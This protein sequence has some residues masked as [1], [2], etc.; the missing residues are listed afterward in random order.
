MLLVV[1]VGVTSVGCSSMWDAIR[2]KQRQSSITIAREFVKRGEWVRAMQSLERAQTRRQLGDFAAESVYLKAKCLDALGRYE[3]ALAHWRMLR[4]QYADARWA[5]RI[6]DEIE[7]LLGEPEPLRARLAPAAFEM[8]K[9]RYGVGA[10]RA[11]VA[12]PVWVEYRL[13]E[14]GVSTDL[15]VVGPAHPLLAAYALEAVAQ[16][17][18]RESAGVNTVLPRRALSPFRFESLW[19]D[20]AEDEPITGGVEPWPPPPEEET[21][22]AEEEE[23]EDDGGFEIEWF[24]QS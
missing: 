10:R 3:E 12:G 24:P 1:V 9:P 16:G 2:E 14:N 21:E 23:D 20:E 19:M 17:R 6:P 7:P 11:S 8:A 4:G 15:R 13:D 22:A 5:R 18:W